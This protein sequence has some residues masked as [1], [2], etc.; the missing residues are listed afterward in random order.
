MTENS[1]KGFIAEMVTNTSNLVRG[2][3]IIMILSLILSASIILVIKNI[4]PEKD[5]VVTEITNN[6]FK[7]LF[8]DQK[9]ELFYLNFHSSMLW[10]NDPIEIYSGD[11]VI[12]KASGSYNTA[13]H[14][15]T[16]AANKD[17]RPVYGWIDPNGI[18]DCKL[19]RPADKLRN[20]YKIV[21]AANYGALLLQFVP[22]GEA[23]KDRPEPSNVKIVNT[24]YIIC[25][26]KFKENGSIYFAVNEVP[27]DK[28]SKDIYIITKE[29]DKEYEEKR[30]EKEQLL[31]W[32]NIEDSAYWDIWYDDNIGTI[33]LTIEIIRK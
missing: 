22:N 32:K 15:L 23:K 30:S 5:I 20:P 17:F 9:K 19:N 29:E 18:P 7:I 2:I 26:D 12:I 16:N 21:S 24:G 31:A 11:S 1:N 4:L 13:I 6:G 25:R 27:L 33:F 3:I 28:D 14:H 8:K 10:E